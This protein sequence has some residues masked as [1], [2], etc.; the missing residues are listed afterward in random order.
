MTRLSPSSRAR[1]SFLAGGLATL[2]AAGCGNAVTALSHD[3][4]AGTSGS[5][6]KNGSAGTNGSGGTN[7]GGGTNGAGGTTG[8]GGTGAGGQIGKIP[9]GTTQ[10]SDGK[11]N[12]GDG[13]IDSADPECTGPADND[14]SSYATG[15]PGDN[16]DACKQD[17]FLDG[18][19]GMGDDGCQWQL[20]CDPK[21]A[22][23]KCPFSQSYVDKHAMECSVSASQSQHCIDFCRKFVPNGCD[24]FGCCAVPGAP[25]PIRLDPTCTSKDFGDPT[26]CSPCTQ[27]TQ[28]MNTCDRC[29]LCVGKTTVPADCGY[30]PP[31]PGDG[32]VYDGGSD[33]PPPPP[34]GGYGVPQCSGYTSCVPGPN[35]MCPTGTGCVTGCCIPIIP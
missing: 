1:I 17:C 23:A 12:D 14:E 7:G 30:T 15:I 5:A 11:D 22:N 27:V 18:N 28:C 29:E 10:C 24:C 33:T 19:S 8:G 9:L 26:K 2:L 32:G 31:P 21:S 3:G 16:V 4:G 25:T 35:A 6:G 34:D 13:L 20:Q